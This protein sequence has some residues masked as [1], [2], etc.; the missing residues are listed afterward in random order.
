MPSNI[1]Q[2]MFYILIVLSFKNIRSLIF[3]YCDVWI[4]VLCS[5]HYSVQYSVLSAGVRLRLLT[6]AA[7]HR[8][9]AQRRPCASCYRLV[10]P[11][12]P[13]GAPSPLLPASGA[14]TPLI[15]AGKRQPLAAPFRL[16]PQGSGAPAPP[17]H[18][19]VVTVGS[20]SRT[21]HNLSA[22]SGLDNFLVSNKC[23]I[24]FCHSQYKWQPTVI[25]KKAIFLN[26]NEVS[27]KK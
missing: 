3:V 14:Q 12:R 5:V 4:W 19:P 26:T 22:F 23:S 6:C 17:C 2:R 8:T 18:Q 11:M 21:H 9:A 27:S 13:N 16:L 15:G 24:L 10:A 7:T 1:F 25:T 20:Q